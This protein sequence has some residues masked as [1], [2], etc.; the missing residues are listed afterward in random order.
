VYIYI[1]IGTKSRREIHREFWK[2]EVGR[3]T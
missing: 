2:A 1:N 3:I